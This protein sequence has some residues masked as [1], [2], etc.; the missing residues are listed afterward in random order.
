MLATRLMGATSAAAANIEY[1]GGYVQGF[2]GTSS[3][4]TISLTS[5]T[6]GLASAPA[7]GDFVIIYFGTGSSVDR[8]LVVSGY[9]EVTELNTNST[10]E[11]NLVVA[12]KFMGGT[13]D[14][15]ITLTG[16]TLSSNDA[17]AVAIQ[18]WRGINQTTPFDVTQRTAISNTGVRINPSS[19]TPLTSGAV[20]IAGGAGGH[21]EGVQTY[22]GSNLTDLISVGAA[23]TYDVSIGLGYSEWTSGVFDPTVFTFSSG[24]SSDYSYAAVTLAL[25]PA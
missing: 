24:N 6:G 18:V 20:I 12:Y 17:G 8:N 16:G 10:Y 7:A 13:P 2:V 19:I 4:V 23:D 21:N 15:S 9:T 1:V 3:N 5:L 25:R 11:A 22:S 14:T